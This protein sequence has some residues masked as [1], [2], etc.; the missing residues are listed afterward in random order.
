MSCF[1]GELT[2]K[3]EIELSIAEFSVLECCMVFL[4][5]KAFWD[6]AF[7]FESS[8]LRSCFSSEN[9]KF[10][11]HLFRSDETCFYILTSWNIFI[12]LFRAKILEKIFLFK[13][14]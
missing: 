14:L 9:F 10:V 4:C 5:E 6:V 7:S 2:Q 3:E 1:S 8:D 12:S 11:A 13:K